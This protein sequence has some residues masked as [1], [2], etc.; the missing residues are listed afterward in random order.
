MSK[1]GRPNGQ[2][3]KVYA[4]PLFRILGCNILR[5]SWKLSLGRNFTIFAIKRQLAKNCSCKKF[6]SKNFLLTIS[7]AQ[8]LRA[9]DQVNQQKV[10]PFCRR[11]ISKI[12]IAE[13]FRDLRSTRRNCEWILGVSSLPLAWQFFAVSNRHALVSVEILLSFRRW[14]YTLW[15]TNFKRE[16]VGGVARHDLVAQIKIAKFFSCRVCW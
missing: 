2:V 11:S 5:Y 6:S 16:I 1:S 12:L 9:A 3:V 10:D 13:V 14:K 4:G 8:Y 7:R 15:V